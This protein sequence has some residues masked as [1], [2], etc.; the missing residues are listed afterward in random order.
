[1]T[2]EAYNPGIFIAPYSG[3]HLRRLV[4]ETIASNSA[5]AADTLQ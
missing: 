1:M 2:N 4:D 5:N 3:V